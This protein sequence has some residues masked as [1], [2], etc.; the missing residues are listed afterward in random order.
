MC[1][2]THSPVSPCLVT[3]LVCG[4]LPYISSRQTDLPFVLLRFAPTRT[5]RKYRACRAYR[6]VGWSPGNVGS[7]FV[8]DHILCSGST[9]LRGRGMFFAPV[10][11]K[12]K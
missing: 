12:K 3:C 8:C 11:I 5:L 9:P 2:C 6:P 10:I 7:Q 1:R 4:A